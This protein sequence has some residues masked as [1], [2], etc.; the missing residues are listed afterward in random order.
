MILAAPAG[1]LE[2]SQPVA[3]AGTVDERPAALEAEQHG[4][5]KGVA[6]PRWI[7]D[8]GRLDAGNDRL[9]ALLPHLAAVGCERHDDAAQVRA[10]HRLDR[11]AGSLGKHL[12]LV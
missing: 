7:D 6:A 5:A 12:R 4:A 10:R 9:L 11:A 3:E 8:L 2:R 1:D